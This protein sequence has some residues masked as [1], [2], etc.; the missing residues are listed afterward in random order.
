[1][2]KK[3]GELDAAA[4][5][6]DAQ[7]KS[8]AA[9]VLAMQAKIKAVWDDEKALSAICDL[10]DAMRD[11]T[12]ALKPSKKVEGSGAL[13][14]DESYSNFAK[15]PVGQLIVVLQAVDPIVF[16]DGNLLA[17]RQKKSQRKPP[18][19]EIWKYLEYATDQHAEDTIPIAPFSARLPSDSHQKS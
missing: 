10:I 19:E 4:K 3:L 2:P 9:R 13:S 5:V 1:M 11:Q 18:K 16:S 15:T 14:W 8:Q 12:P 7:R 17:L 6:L